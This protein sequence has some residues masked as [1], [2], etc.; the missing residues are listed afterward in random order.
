MRVLLL[1]ASIRAAVTNRNVPQALS[2]S[3]LSHAEIPLAE[4]A[5]KRMQRATPSPY[6]CGGNPTKDYPGE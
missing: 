2:A 1:Q 3:S 6:D 4:E 5:S